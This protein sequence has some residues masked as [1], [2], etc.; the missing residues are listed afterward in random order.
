MMMGERVAPADGM[1]CAGNLK[2]GYFLFG[3]FLLCR[4]LGSILL[5][6]FPQLNVLP[7]AISSF[8][9]MNHFRGESFGR[10]NEKTLSPPGVQVV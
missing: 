3:G 9:I 6:H 8:V 10:G 5:P 1:D 2:I 4:F 7:W